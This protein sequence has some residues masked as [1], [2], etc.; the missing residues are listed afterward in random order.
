M[1]G[2]MFRICCA[3]FLL[4]AAIMMQ[5]ASVMFAGRA[6]GASQ[7][8]LSFAMAAFSVGLYV[9]GPLSSYLVARFQR[10]NVYEV[11]LLALAAVSGIMYFSRDVVSVALVRFLEGA[12]CGLAQVSLGST[13]L[14]DLTVSERRTLSDYYFAWS[15]ILAMPA[16]MAAAYYAMPV[17][18]FDAVLLASVLMMLLSAFVVMRIRVPFRAP[19]NVKLFSCDRFWQKND[20]LPFINLLLLSTTFGMFIAA[21]RQPLMFAFAALGVLAAYPL[22][23]MVFTDADVRAE[24][25]TGMILVLAALLIPFATS[26]AASLHAAALLFG[27]GIGL[28]SSRFLLYFLKMTGHCQRGTAQNTYMLSREC[29]YAAGFVCAFF[30]PHPAVI[31]IPVAVFS[32]AFYLAVTH[33][34][35]LKHNDRYFKFREV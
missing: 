30:V 26:S 1:N 25:V 7:C 18:G 4:M 14:N 35:F 5:L 23:K 27:A 6:G 19:I 16:G 22:R 34:W 9:L 21:N 3:N 13:L 17:A 15:A 20:L 33:P 29:G 8:P 11:S 10:K 32:M 12:V 2:V 31:A 28:S 24:I